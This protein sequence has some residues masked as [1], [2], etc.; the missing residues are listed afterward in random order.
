M[1]LNYDGGY[2]RSQKY[3][4]WKMMDV[5]NAVTNVL[6]NSEERYIYN[7]SKYCFYQNKR[8]MMVITHILILIPMIH[9]ILIVLNQVII[10]ITRHLSLKQHSV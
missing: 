10:L 6:S 9:I 5:M 7:A 8:M 2:L 1:F 3:E 4:R